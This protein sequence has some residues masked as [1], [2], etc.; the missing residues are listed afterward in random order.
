MLCGRHVLGLLRGR[1]ALPYH[2]RFCCRADEVIHYFG[3]YTARKGFN[4]SE[5]NQLILNFKKKMDRRGLLEWRYKTA[6]I[7]TA[8]TRFRGAL[9]EEALKQATHIPIPPSKSRTDPNYDDRVLKM[10]QVAC[11]GL[12][13]DIREL[14]YQVNSIP[15][16]HESDDRPT[17]TDLRSNYAINEAIAG[18]VP[19]LMLVYDDVL[20]TG[21][22]FKA[23][24][25]ILSDRYP[26]VRIIGLFI[27]RRVPDADLEFDAI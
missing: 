12:G 17:P 8:G 1:C 10:I 9:K 18:K 24:R 14:V 25:S 7:D 20:T 26:H 5:T 15:A 3:E 16:A 23:M 11:S 27:A 13:A 21:A 22:H 4:H 6:A 2:N 19:E